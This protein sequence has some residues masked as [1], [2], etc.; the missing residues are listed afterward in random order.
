MKDLRDSLLNTLISRVRYSECAVSDFWQL[1]FQT[2]YHDYER[3]LFRLKN[4]ELS[5]TISEKE[6]EQL[7]VKIKKLQAEA[8]KEQQ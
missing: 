5:G 4:M 1:Y 6:A 2:K 3:A 7:S 8:R